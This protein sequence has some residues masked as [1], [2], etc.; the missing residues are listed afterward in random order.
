[1]SSNP[2]VTLEAW[3]ASQFDPPPSERTL[4]RWVKDGNI[5]PAPILVGRRYYVQKDAKHI[6]EAMQTLRDRIAA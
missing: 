1:M 2:K 5:V 6:S 3:A 4:R